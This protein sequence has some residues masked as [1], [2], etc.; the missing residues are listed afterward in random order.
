MDQQSKYRIHSIRNKKYYNEKKEHNKNGH[1][2]KNTS[3]TQEKK[4]K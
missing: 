2:Y 4:F 1:K 3:K